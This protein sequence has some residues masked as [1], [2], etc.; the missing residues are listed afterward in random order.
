VRETFRTLLAGAV[1]ICLALPVTASELRIRNY[2]G[3]LDI[4]ID[5]S[6]T[7]ISVDI[8][9]RARLI[10]EPRVQ[11]VG[12][13]VVVSGRS[14][15]P[16][17][18]CDE[19][20]GQLFV[21]V[22]GL[23]DGR[24]LDQYPH[25]TVRAPYGVSLTIIDSLVFG[26]AGD[27]DNASLD[28]KGCGVFAIGNVS[29]RLNVDLEG[30]GGFTAGNARVVELNAIGSS[31]VVLGDVS[32]R[33]NVDLAGSGSMWVNQAT[34]FVDLTLSGEGAITVGEGNADRL[35]VNLRGPGAVTFTGR[36]GTAVLTLNGTGTISVGGVDGVSRVSERGGGIIEIGE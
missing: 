25:M 2:Y 31:D 27:L 4:V 18:I 13:N 30:A 29:G 32:E 3:V 15:R 23:V 6:S 34:R 10:I 5:G 33:L 8:D 16:N 11:R 35:N 12:G 20:D 28:L 36:A 9:S 19:R 14:A 26:T 21:R 7:E 17:A 24:P 1:L 22:D